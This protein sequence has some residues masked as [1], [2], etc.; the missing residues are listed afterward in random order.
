MEIEQTEYEIS[1]ITRDNKILSSRLFFLLKLHSYQTRAMP[2][3]ETYST[4][5][6]VL[7]EHYTDL[8]IYLI[9]NNF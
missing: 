4:C 8:V 9:L 2:K 5:K 6:L 3:S 1:Y 7:L